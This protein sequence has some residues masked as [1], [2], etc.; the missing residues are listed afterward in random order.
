MYTILETGGKQYRVRVGDIIDIDKVN[1]AP[2]DTLS[3]D[4]VLMV[5][6]TDE[7]LVGH[8]TLPQVKVV[9]EILGEV[10]G[11]KITVF[12][13]KRRKDYRKK[14]GHRQHLTRVAIR[15]IETGPAG[16]QAVSAEEVK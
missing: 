13:H 2:G 14:I 8:P 12:K 15:K 1:C 9:G 3:F 4:R 7:T 5:A 6:G 10:K 11:P 16:E